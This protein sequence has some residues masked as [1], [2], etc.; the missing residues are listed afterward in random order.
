MH[1][2]VDLS[3]PDTIGE[4]ISILEKEVSFIQGS[5]KY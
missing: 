1:Y 5:T 3:K 4:F 2:T